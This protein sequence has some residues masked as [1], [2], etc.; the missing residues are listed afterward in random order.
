MKR[1]ISDLAVFGGVP[2]FERPRPIGQLAIPDKAEFFS[3]AR[4]IFEKRW[5][6]NNGQQVQELERSL[7]ELHGTKHCLVFANATLALILLLDVV[8]KKA[9]GEIIMPA[10]TYVGLPHIARWAGHQPVFCDINPQTHTIDPASVESCLSADTAAI[11]GVHQAN[12][13]CDIETLTSISLA[14]NIPLVFDSVH[15]SHA[16]YKGTPIGQF[17]V[18]EV[19]S[20]H[21]TKLLNG[22]EGGYITTNSDDIAAQLSAKRNFGIGG[23]G[24]VTTLGLNAK[25]NEIHAAFALAGLGQQNEIVVRNKERYF[26]YLNSFA[27][28]P[29]LDWVH[30]PE[31]ES[32][33]YEFALLIV[34]EEFPVKRDL[35]VELLRAEK[36]L[37]RPYYSPPL[38]HLAENITTQPPS[39]PN[40]EYAAQRI[41]QMPVG[42]Q[43]TVD[44]I[45]ALAGF[46]RFVYDNA[47]Q[48]LSQYA[49]GSQSL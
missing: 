18:A 13:P 30:Y 17:G 33:N 35:L 32:S 40:T 1:S 31:T 24:T 7:R 15:G 12:S 41:I 2:L 11:L 39:L 6:T 42:E 27:S 5:L 34:T 43:V 4:D 21:A 38:H 14:H 16:T 44:D 37:A 9:H 19:F 29:G 47:A 26:A 3:R 22:F 25:L 45:H 28:F 46:V 23:D 48:I 49:T 8:A 36:A 20:L 10:F